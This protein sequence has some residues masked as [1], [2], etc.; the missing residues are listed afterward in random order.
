MLL[1]TAR[2]NADQ[3]CYTFSMSPRAC[4]FLEV[5]SKGAAQMKFG[6]INLALAKNRQSP[7]MKNFLTIASTDYS[8]CFH[9]QQFP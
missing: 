9:V 1:P 3:L 8:L 6:G 4:Q 5:S 7:Q 2:T